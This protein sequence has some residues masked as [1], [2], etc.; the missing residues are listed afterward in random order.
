M[1]DLLSVGCEIITI[2]QYLQPTK[3]NIP[4]VKYVSDDEFKKYA[5]IAKQKG[6]K[7]VESASLVRSSYHADKHV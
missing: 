3:D 6:F 5:K 1:D 2:G 4:V 7:F